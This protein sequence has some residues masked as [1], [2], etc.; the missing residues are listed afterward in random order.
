[1][2]QKTAIYLAV[3]LA[4]AWAI[5]HFFL[6]SPGLVDANRRRAT[7]PLHTATAEELAGEVVDLHSGG[8]DP[9]LASSVD[10]GGI[11]LVGAP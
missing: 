2:N 4:A 5:W 10:A 11:P 6:R 7:K 8:H 1:M 9:A 3:G